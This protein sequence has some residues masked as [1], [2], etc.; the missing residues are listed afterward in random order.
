MKA[1]KVTMQD[2]SQWIVPADIVA[3]DA[4]TYYSTRDWEDHD[5]TYTY[6]VNDDGELL[7]WAEG[8]MEWEDVVKHARMVTGPQAPNYHEAW[9]NGD[10]EIVDIPDK[11]S[12]EK[13][14]TD[15]VES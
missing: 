13:G 6:F 12:S 4:A 3:K 5:E 8:N 14:T 2:G 15:E 7:N 10:K 1:I 9:I 11:P